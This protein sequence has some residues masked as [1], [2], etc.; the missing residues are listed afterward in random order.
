LEGIE[1]E[2]AQRWNARKNKAHVGSFIPEM[3]FIFRVEA[4]SMWSSVV[5]LRRT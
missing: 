3:F 4:A 5:V 1:G 2:G